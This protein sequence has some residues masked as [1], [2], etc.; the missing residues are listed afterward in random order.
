MLK[1]VE[2]SKFEIGCETGCETGVVN[3]PV[4]ATSSGGASEKLRHRR[5]IVGN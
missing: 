1:L 3:L 4:I 5:K 2:S